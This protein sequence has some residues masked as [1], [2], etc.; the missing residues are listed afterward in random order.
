MSSEFTLTGMTNQ[1][2]TQN[3]SERRPSYSRLKPRLQR[4]LLTSP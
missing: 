2:K 1:R 3:R 4:F